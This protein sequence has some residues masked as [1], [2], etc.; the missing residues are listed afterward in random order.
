MSELSPSG[1]TFSAP[2]HLLIKTER[3]VLSAAEQPSQ[4]AAVVNPQAG[5]SKRR[6]LHN[7]IL[8]FTGLETRLNHPRASTLE[9]EPRSSLPLGF[10]FQ[11]PPALH[12]GIVW[13]DGGRVGLPCPSRP[14]G[15]LA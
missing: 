12:S 15:G 13:Q 3:A 5:D 8:F 4:A 7:A 10:P 1:A 14:S 9:R 11:S 6:E 2:A